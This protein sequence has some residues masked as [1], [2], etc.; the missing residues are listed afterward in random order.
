MT[1]LAKSLSLI[2]NWTTIVH[3]LQHHSDA[4]ATWIVTNCNMGVLPL[5]QL[6]STNQTKK[7][8]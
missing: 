1:M 3:R 4:I 8:A 5:Q 7:Y 6:I 2:Q